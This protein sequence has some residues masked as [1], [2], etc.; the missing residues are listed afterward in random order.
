[1][2]DDVQNSVFYGGYVRSWMNGATQVFLPRADED[3]VFVFTHILQHF[4]CGGIG[5]RQICDWIRLLWKYKES[6]DLVLLEKRIRKMGIMT[7]WI[8]FAALAVEILGMPED[9]MP[10][11]SKSKK[12]IRKADRV[13]SLVMEVGNFGHNRDTSYLHKDAILIRKAK[14]FKNLT[15]DNMRQIAIF[16]LDTLKVWSNMFVYRTKL[17]IFSH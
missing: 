16:P 2:L 1:M 3:V 13:L 8:V 10:F 12:W 14:T 5:L 15:W 7:E 6:L 9:A 17:S 4:Y 11:Y